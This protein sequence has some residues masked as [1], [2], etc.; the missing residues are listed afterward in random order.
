MYKRQK[1][2]LTTRMRQH[3]PVLLTR[4]PH[5]L[6]LARHPAVL[7]VEETVDGLLHRDSDMDALAVRKNGRQRTGTPKILSSSIH[8]PPSIAATCRTDKDALKI[9]PVI[10]PYSHTC[11]YVVGYT[12]IA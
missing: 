10:I 1:S 5:A 11:K 7:P 12:N 2:Q 3:H 6:Q 9:L 4:N 8:A